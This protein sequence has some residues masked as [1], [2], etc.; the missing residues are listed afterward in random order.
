MGRDHSRDRDF[1][2]RCPSPSKSQWD[3]VANFSVTWTHHNGSVLH[4]L[5]R[6][7]PHTSR[8]GELIITPLAETQHPIAEV[9]Q[10]R[11]LER[12]NGALVHLQADQGRWRFEFEEP[13]RWFA[14]KI[15]YDTAKDGTV[16][17][18]GGKGKWICELALHFPNGSRILSET[19]RGL[20]TTDTHSHHHHHQQHKSRRR[21]IKANHSA[22]LLP[23]TPNKTQ[24]PMTAKLF[25]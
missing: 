22:E 23:S 8:R 2:L 18:E 3:A 21:R 6:I 19:S 11:T 15:P 12:R 9:K 25:A 10:W 7:A 5:L 20:E 16:K 1:V 4:P 17:E 24:E 13:T 14:L